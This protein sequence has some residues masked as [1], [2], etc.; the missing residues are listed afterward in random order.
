MAESP[1]VI[2]TGAGSGVGRASSL[3]LA[4]EGARLTLIGRAEKN[5]RETARLI[6][7]KHSH[8][9]E[10][11]AISADVSHQDQCDAAVRAAAE[12]WGTVH[13]LIN[14][15]GVVDTR[16]VN[17]VDEQSLQRVFGVNTFGPA[18]LSAACWPHFVR[19]RGGR[20][21]NVS[22][23][24]TVDPFPGLAM[25]AAAKS[26]L[27]SYTRSIMVEGKAHNILGFSVVL[28]AVET[29]MLRRVVSTEELPTSRT[30]DPLDAGRII[31]DCAMGRRDVDA[32]APLI[33]RKP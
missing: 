17:D 15:A 5:V 24:S 7:E 4:S 12:R 23:M 16:P 31:A 1:V 20:I 2:V 29:P 33:V 27:E 11:L 8:L 6:R 9:P 30:L 21:V 26:A 32:G 14:N 25:Y 22:S 19:R 28:G 3:L 10:P 13:A 18:Y